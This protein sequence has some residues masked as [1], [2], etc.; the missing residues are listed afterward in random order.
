VADGVADEVELNDIDDVIL[1]DRE[2]DG[3]LDRDAVADTL[4]LNVGVAEYVGV[5]DDDKLVLGVT[6]GVGLALG[7]AMQYNLK[8]SL[9][10]MT[11]PPDPTANECCTAPPN[12]KLHNTAPVAPC[13]A[14]TLRSTLPTYSVP[15]PPTAGEPTYASL[16]E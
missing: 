13:K 5:A 8:S 6:E 15:S 16:A 7:L 1:E 14:T 9:P 11:V 12:E 4:V 3:V 10:T 2:A